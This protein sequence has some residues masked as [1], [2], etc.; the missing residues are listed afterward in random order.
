MCEGR[1][2]GERQVKTSLDEWNQ[3]EWS[4]KSQSSRSEQQVDVFG[5][6]CGESGGVEGSGEFL[7]RRRWRAK[8]SQPLDKK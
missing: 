5:S 3:H 1:R 8:Q 2:E 4:E 6:D 7:L